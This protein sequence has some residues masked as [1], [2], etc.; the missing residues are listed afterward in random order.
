MSQKEPLRDCGE[1][2]AQLYN[3]I[4]NSSVGSHSL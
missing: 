3:S 4:L 1:A 2:K